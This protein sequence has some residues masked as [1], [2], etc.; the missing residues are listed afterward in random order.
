MDMKRCVLI[1]FFD[2][3]VNDYHKS[4]IIS[5]KGGRSY[6]MRDIDFN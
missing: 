3:H 2:I 4:E 1:F 5:R 6:E